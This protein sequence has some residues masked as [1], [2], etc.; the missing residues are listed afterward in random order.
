MTPAEIL[1]IPQFDRWYPGQVELSSQ[2]SAWLA[3]PNRFLGA[4]LPTGY[5]K[6]LLG[7]LLAQENLQITQENLRIT[8]ENKVVYLTSTKGL[9]EQLMRDF[10]SLGVVDIRGQ[11][12]YQCIQFP[13]RT[14]DLAPCHTGY[15]CPVRNECTYYS[16]LE[17]AKGA[18]IVVTNYHYW[19][20]QHQYGSGLDTDDNMTNLLICDEAHQ[21]GNALESYLSLR[22]TRRDRR[23]IPWTVDWTY[24]DWVDAARSARWRMEQELRRITEDA[25]ST[26]PGSDREEDLVKEQRYLRTLTNK[27]DNVISG[28]ISQWIPESKDDESTWTPIRPGMYNSELFQN[29]PKVLCMSAMFTQHM[30]GNLNIQ[31]D[32]IDAPSPFPVRNTPIMHVNTVRMDYRTSDEDMLAWVRRI[33]EIIGDRSGKKGLVF[34]VSY[35]RARFLAQHSRYVGLMYQHTSRDIAQVVQDFKDAP[36]PAVLVSPSVTTGYDFPAEE[37]EYIIVGKIP[38]PDSRSS[39]AKARQRENSSY[40]SQLAMEVLVQEAGRGTRSATD[41]CQVIIVDDTWRWWWPKYQELA[42]SWFR[43]RVLRS[44]LNTVPIQI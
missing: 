4:A 2:L 40:T 11:N 12:D 28:R 43:E 15:E 1:G 44:S 33:D 30:M 31:G 3:G 7:M 34:T 20:Y 37:C 9:Q 38:Y 22:F 10:S 19:L 14:V 6:S 8:Q 42:P 27:L 18:R 16:T 26:T 5:G 21:L 41:R 36:A 13:Q 32:W 17:R 23:W 24:Q 35:A 29:V 25:G 39:L